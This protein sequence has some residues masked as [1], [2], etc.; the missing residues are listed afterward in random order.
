MEPTPTAT[1]RTCA[2]PSQ[3]WRREDITRGSRYRNLT[4]RDISQFSLTSPQLLCR[5]GADTEDV[6]RLS[7]GMPAL[8]LAIAATYHHLECFAALLLYGAKPGLSELEFD[9]LPSSVIT[10]CSVP[11]AIIKYR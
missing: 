8:P 4:F 3:L 1:S 5:Y 11:H 10:Q 2:R 9:S 7:S 6:F